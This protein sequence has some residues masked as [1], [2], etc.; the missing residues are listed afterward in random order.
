MDCSIA[1]N[2][3]AEY[4]A[5]NRGLEIAIREGYQRLQIEDDSMLVIE[6][7]KQI[8]Q[9][10]LAEK[11]SKSWRTAWVIIDVKKQLQ[12]LEYTISS[13]VKRKGNA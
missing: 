10:T 3:E 12:R 8:Q 9:G 2:N 6:T 5:I 11:L 4:H 7:I 1:T 13:H